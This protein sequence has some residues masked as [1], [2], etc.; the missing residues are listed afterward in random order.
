VVVPQAGHL[1]N[2]EDP[3]AVTAAI[4]QFLGVVRGPRHA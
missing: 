3:E 4:L 2:V 1:A